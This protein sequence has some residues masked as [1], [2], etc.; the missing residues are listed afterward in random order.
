MQLS[1]KVFKEKEL[2]EARAVFAKHGLPVSG[3]T[4]GQ[5]KTSSVILFGGKGKKSVVG[6]SSKK[7]E[8]KAAGKG[9]VDDGAKSVVSYKSMGNKSNGCPHCQQ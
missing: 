8:A 4:G 9:I 5:S 1:E 3:L 2:E 7:R 6:S